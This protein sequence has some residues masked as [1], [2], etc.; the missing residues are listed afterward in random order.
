MAA[1]PQRGHLRRAWL[2][3]TRADLD[4]AREN[5]RLAGVDLDQVGPLASIASFSGWSHRRMNPRRGP[6]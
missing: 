5:A 4:K 2:T 1:D 6:A 3:R